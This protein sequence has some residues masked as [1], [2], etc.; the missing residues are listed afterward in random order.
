MGRRILWIH[1]HGAEPLST[2]VEGRMARGGRVTEFCCAT[3]KPECCHSRIS[4]TMWR[5]SQA[6]PKIDHGDESGTRPPRLAEWLIIRFSPAKERDCVAG[7]L[8]EE[9]REIRLPRLGR[10][11]ARRWYRGQVLRSLLHRM[12]SRR[13]RSEARPEL[14]HDDTTTTRVSQN[15]EGLM[16]TFIQ[17]I[18]YGIRTLLQSPTFSVLTVLTLALAIGVNTAIFSMINVLLLRPLPIADTDTIGFIYSTNP[19]RSIDRAYV[20]EADFLDFRRELRSFSALAGVGRGTSLVMT[21]HEDPVRIIGWEATANTFDVWGMEPLLGRTFQ[22]GEDLPG[23]ERVVLLSHGTWERRFGSDPGVLGRTLRLDGFETTIIGVLAPELE[24]GSLAEAEVWVPLR[25]DLAAADRERRYLW[26]SGRLAPGVTL[27]QA[28]EEVSAMS[29]RLAAEYPDTNT[30]WIYQGNSMKQALATD[31]VWTIFYLLGLTVTFVMLIACSNVATMMLAR[32]SART[33]EIAVRAALGAGRVRILRQLLTESLV[34]SVCAGILGLFVAQASLAGLVWMVGTNSG[35]NFFELLTIDR[36]VLAFTLVVSAV[37]PLL[38]G[39]FPA[40]RAARTDL[41]ETLKDS[42]RGSSGASGLRGRRILVTTQVALALSLMVVAGLLIDDMIDTR[43]RE[44]GFEY[45]GVLTMRVDLAEGK[46]P[47]ERQWAAFFDEVLTRAESLPAVENAAW[48]SRLPLIDGAARREFLVEGMPVPP[49][50]R[51]NWTDIVVVSPDYIDAL[52][53]PLI[54]GRNLTDSDEAEGIQVAL[55][56]QELAERYLP[57]RDAIGERIRLGSTD[58]EQPWLE[59]VGVVGNLATG[60]PDNPATPI[61]YLPLRQNPRQGMVLTTRTRGEPLE[62]VEALRRQVWAVDPEQP[63]GDVR[64]M[65]R[66]LLDGLAVFDTLISIF[67][68]FA[69]FALVMAST[70]IYGVISFSVSQRAQEIGIR[71]ALG[72]ESGDVL[73]MIVRQSLWLVGIGVAVGTVGAFALGQ[74]LASAVVGLNGADPVALGG[75]VLV[76]G[77]AAVIATLIPAR[78]AVRI[79]PVTAL[80]SE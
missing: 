49:P 45:R 31:Q 25:L 60:D 57:G 54:Q 72:A 6:A 73:R 15:R 55:V 76:L 46:Y 37:A 21:G 28:R 3:M 22:E 70:G 69:V 80:R 41:S 2:E 27:N 19:Q 7:D 4:S 68:S 32:A 48:V 78:R 56:N 9:F 77:L 51:S 53:Y 34:L 1:Y 62:A 65:E 52:H 40:L 38:F 20:S 47:E 74:A 23:A 66:M 36:N 5:K 42:T 30:G 26:T 10:S 16:N 24:F 63:I 67:V 18:R 44:V 35:T 33:K 39:F 43:T 17:D 64:T 29:L 75:V 14:P 11:G 61:A 79:D 58:S 12:A 8:A 13:A 59:V 50:E 71:M